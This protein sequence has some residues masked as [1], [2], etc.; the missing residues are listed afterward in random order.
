MKTP[1][2][3]DG[4]QPLSLLPRPVSLTRDHLGAVPGVHGPWARLPRR[5]IEAGAL[6]RGEPEALLGLGIP[7]SG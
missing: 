4:A 5:H 2:S 7:L 3:T 1:R 6:R